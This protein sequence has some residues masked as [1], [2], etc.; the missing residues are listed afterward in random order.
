MANVR[1]SPVLRRLSGVL[2]GVAACAACVG[3]GTGTGAGTT[4]ED[5]APQP[6]RIVELVGVLTRERIEAEAPGWA[7]AVGAARPDVAA[8][9]ELGAVPPGASVDVVLGTWCGDSRREV[10]RL[11]AAL[12]ALSAP[13]PFE[14]RYVGVDRSK[15]EP[16]SLLEG[17]DLRYV[18]TFVVRRDGSEVGRII[19]SAPEGIE[20][21][22]AAL[23]S[24][25]R[26]GVISGRDD[27]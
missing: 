25:A 9:L 20:R 21:D 10:A 23:L 12:D 15:Q 4:V 26:S 22:L 17:L 1:P 18:P 13:V 24:G 7:E 5:D 6:A 11:W 19:E 14:L 2:L 8:A 3:A 27:L 16:Q